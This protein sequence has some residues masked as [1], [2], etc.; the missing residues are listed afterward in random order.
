MN[1]SLGLMYSWV[2]FM[3]FYSLMHHLESCLLFS[4]ASASL[5]TWDLFTTSSFF[6]FFFRRDEHRG[7]VQRLKWPHRGVL[8]LFQCEMLHWELATPQHSSSSSSSFPSPSGINR[9]VFIPHENFSFNLSFSL[10]LGG[11]QK[12]TLWG[13]PAVGRMRVSTVNDLLMFIGNE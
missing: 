3:S 11:G 6:F 10:L 4:A 8:G 5:I 9:K 12:V 13:R 7:Q 1:Y 2:S